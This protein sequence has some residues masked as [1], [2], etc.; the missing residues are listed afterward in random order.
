[1]SVTAMSFYSSYH[2]PW[3]TGRSRPNKTVA[4]KPLSVLKMRVHHTV[5]DFEAYRLFVFQKLYTAKSWEGRTL[6][7]HDGTQSH[8]V[9]EKW[10]TE[11]CRI[12]IVTFGCYQ[13]RQCFH[14]LTQHDLAINPDPY[15]WGFVESN[16]LSQPFHSFYWLPL[17]QCES[18]ISLSLPDFLLLSLSVSVRRKSKQALRD[19]KK[20]QIQLENLETSVRDRCK[21]EFTGKRM[22]EE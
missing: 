4:A 14:F 12:C 18:G 21:K 9:F 7:G 13:I 1:M 19:Y 15:C 3:A 5:T 6:S 20:V 16:Y 11:N 8:D 2:P 22:P 10:H 17:I